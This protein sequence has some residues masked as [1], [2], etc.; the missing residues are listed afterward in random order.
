MHFNSQMPVTVI[1]DNVN[2]TIPI[3]HEHSSNMDTGN[4]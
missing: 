3:V 1:N 2:N 4:G